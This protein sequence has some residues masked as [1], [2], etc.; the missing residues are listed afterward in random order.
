MFVNNTGDADVQPGALGA[1]V[2]NSMWGRLARLPGRPLPQRLVPPTPPMAPLPLPCKL[3]HFYNSHMSMIL[4][5]FQPQCAGLG[6]S[7]SARRFAAGFA[8][9]SPS[10]P[11]PSSFMSPRRDRFERPDEGLGDAAG[12][13]DSAGARQRNSWRTAN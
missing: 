6:D 8:A 12:F 2:P 11:P 1:W 10:P 7:A 5:P 3:P 9:G 4:K 13:G